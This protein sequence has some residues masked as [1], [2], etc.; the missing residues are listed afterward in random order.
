MAAW[1]LGKDTKSISKWSDVFTFLVLG[2]KENTLKIEPGPGGGQMA[3]ALANG[4]QL[5]W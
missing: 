5:A 2:K 4:F 1:Y 3:F